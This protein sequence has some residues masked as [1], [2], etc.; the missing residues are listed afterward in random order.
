MPIVMMCKLPFETRLFNK[1]QKVW[2]VQRSGSLA[3]KVCG[4]HRGRGK[5]ITAWVSWTSC[6]YQKPE[7]KKIEVR[8]QFSDTHNLLTFN[9]I[10]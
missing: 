3:Y 7:W 4:R 10:N 5:Y 9:A 1:N 6:Y 2:V 8:K